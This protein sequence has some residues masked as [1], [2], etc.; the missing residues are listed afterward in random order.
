VL[1]ADAPDIS[2]RRQRPGG[3]AGYIEF[4]TPFRSTVFRSIALL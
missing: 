4:Q 1:L 3:L 2:E